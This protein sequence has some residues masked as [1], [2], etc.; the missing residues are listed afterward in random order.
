M[1]TISLE[2]MEWMAKAF[3]KIQ[4]FLCSNRSFHLLRLMSGQQMVLEQM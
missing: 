4:K 3:T 2:I 1:Q